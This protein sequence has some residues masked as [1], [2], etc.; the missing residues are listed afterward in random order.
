M[1]DADESVAECSQGL[2]VEVAGSSSLI[3]EGSTARACGEGAVRPLLHD[4]VEAAVVDV[5]GE[6]SLFSSRCDGHW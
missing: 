4:V 3:V 2:V 1:E 5:A 6:D